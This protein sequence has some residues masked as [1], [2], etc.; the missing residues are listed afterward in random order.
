MR[1]LH[2]II[3]MSYKLAHALSRHISRRG[4]QMTTRRFG[5]SKILKSKTPTSYDNKYYWLKNT[6]ENKYAFG[7][8]DEF[9]E[10]YGYPQMIFFE[11]DI[12]DILLEGDEFAVI[13]NEKAV[14]SIEVPFDNAKLVYQNEDIDF[15]IV[16]DDPLNLENKICVFED[17]N[18][19]NNEPSGGDTNGEPLYMS[20]L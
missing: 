14:V 15:D 9:M 13:E 4:F 8:T 18:V 1:S 2:S 17:V 12:D 10:E 7:I 3:K 16:N 6:E 5:L 20:M 19:P 11:A